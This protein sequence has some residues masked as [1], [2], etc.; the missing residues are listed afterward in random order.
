MYSVC[1][2]L[3]IL[4]PLRNELGVGQCML[5]AGEAVNKNLVSLERTRERD[6]KQSHCFHT[7]QCRK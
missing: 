2:D 6:Y 5:G 4:S 7:H 3:E 1:I